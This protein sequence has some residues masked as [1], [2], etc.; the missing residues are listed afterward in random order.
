M[1]DNDRVL[2]LVERLKR[3]PKN[4]RPGKKIQ[5]PDKVL[6]PDR[7]RRTIDYWAWLWRRPWNTAFIFAFAIFHSVVNELDILPGDKVVMI[8]KRTKKVRTIIF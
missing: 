7:L 1:T 3:L 2:S 6:V 5:T 4:Y 8:N